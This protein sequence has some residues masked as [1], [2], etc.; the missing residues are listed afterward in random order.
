MK[1]AGGWW[2]VAGMA[3]GVLCV[4]TAGCGYSLAGRGTFLPDYIKIVGDP[5]VNMANTPEI[6]GGK[7]TYASA[8]NYIPLMSGAPAGMQTVVD[9]PMPRYWAPTV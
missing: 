9:L 7:G 6:P 2:L 4:A 5:N 8:G 1:V 3:L